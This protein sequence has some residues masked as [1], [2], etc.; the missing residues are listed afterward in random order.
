[1]APQRANR[2]SKQASKQASEQQEWKQAEQVSS[3]NARKMKKN[4]QT[5]T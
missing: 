1:M 4:Y 2:A 3:K 5:K